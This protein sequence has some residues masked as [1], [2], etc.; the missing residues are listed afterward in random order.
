MCFVLQVVGRALCECVS[1]GESELV[2]A[3]ALDTLYDV[4]GADECPVR[5]LVDLQIIPT[6]KRVAAQ[7]SD[8]VRALCVYTHIHTHT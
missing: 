3:R 5:L 1:C 6:L 7:F 4:F 2:V 8:R